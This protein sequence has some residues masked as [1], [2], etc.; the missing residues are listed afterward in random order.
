MDRHSGPGGND[1]RPPFFVVFGNERRME[2]ILASE[3][4]ALAFAHRMIRFQV[5][6]LNILKYIRQI[7]D[8]MQGGV[9]IIDPRH[10]RTAQNDR[11]TSD[12]FQCFCRTGFRA[13]AGIEQQFRFEGLRFGVVTSAATQRAAFDENHGSPVRHAPRI[14]QCRKRL[15]LHSFV[16]CIV[17]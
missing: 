10:Q 7:G 14:F 8:M 5:D 16:T 3:I 6:P 4:A 15:L 17:N 13:F 1:L 12:G 11:I 2:N 9:C